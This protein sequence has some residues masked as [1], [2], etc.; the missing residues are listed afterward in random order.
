MSPGAKNLLQRIGTAALVLPPVVWVLLTGGWPA[1]ALIAAASAVAAFEFY[2]LTVGPLS[3]H[4]A[5]PLLVAGILPLLPQAAPA[6]AASLAL[7]LLVATSVWG[8]S[9]YV[10]RGDVDGGA[11]HGPM[12]VQGVVFCALGPFALACL[13]VVPG[14]EAWVLTVVAATFGNDAFALFGGKLLGRHK[15][16]PAV[17]PGKTWEGLFSGALGSLA[18]PIGGHFLWPAVLTWADVAA[19]ALI[20]AALGPLGDL[21]KSL[22]KRSRQVKDAGHLLPGHGGM[23]DRIDALVVNA[24]AVWVWVTWLR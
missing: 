15:L 5:L 6:S 11:A 17:S 14:G 3:V 1:A 8:W 20:T 16:A 7:A 12:I 10:L 19:L 13:R 21:M 4:T 23:L 9:S 2:R 24:P 18:A 22:I